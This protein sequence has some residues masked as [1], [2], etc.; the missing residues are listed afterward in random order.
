MFVVNEDEAAPAETTLDL[1]LWDDVPGGSTVVA[2]L[3]AEGCGPSSQA[4]VYDHCK[5]PHVKIGA[6]TQPSLLLSAPWRLCNKSHAGQV[7]LPIG[8]IT[9]KVQHMMLR[10]SGLLMSGNACCHRWMGDVAAMVPYVGPP[11]TTSELRITLPISSIARRVPA[12]AL[13]RAPTCNND[14][15]VFRGP[16][17]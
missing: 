5:P 11:T 3:V 8:R 10:S 15:S 6:K 4:V 12:L 13:H 7:K 1:E 17:T 16:M 9:I 14:V 2:C